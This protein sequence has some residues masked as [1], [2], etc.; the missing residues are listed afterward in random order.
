MPGI[1]REA[2]GLIQE[3]DQIRAADPAD[4]V[5]HDLNIRITKIRDSGSCPD[6]NMLWSLIRG[7]SEK[8]MFVPK[9]QP[10]SFNPKIKSNPAKIS[11]CFIRQY[12]PSPH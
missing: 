3:R 2:A 5:I 6:T 1:S 7:L 10:I 4:P 12:V 8:R 9:N 11:E